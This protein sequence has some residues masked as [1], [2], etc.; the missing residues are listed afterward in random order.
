MASVCMHMFNLLQIMMITP[1]VCVIII[2][3]IKREG[4]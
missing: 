2:E 3:C 1:F 4:D